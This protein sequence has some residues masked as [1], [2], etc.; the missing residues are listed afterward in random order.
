[1]AKVLIANMQIIIKGH[2][3]YIVVSLTA[4]SIMVLSL[5]KLGL[6]GSSRV[7]LELLSTVHC[8]GPGQGLAHTLL[9]I[10]MWYM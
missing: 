6:A 8:Q 3:Q 10:S 7:L 5:M 9:E 4:S 1:M 2:L